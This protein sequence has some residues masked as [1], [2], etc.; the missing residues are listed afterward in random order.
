MTVDVAI[1]GGGPAGVTAAQELRRQ[2]VRDVMLLEREAYL[3]GATRHCAH[4]PFGMREFGRVLFGADY[5]RRLES[6]VARAGIDLRYG[7]SVT[8][9]SPEGSLNIANADGLYQITA[10][11]ILLATGARELPRAARMLPG[12]RPIGVITTGTL[13]SMIAF[14]HRLPFRRP[15]IIGSE[16]VTLS[17]LLT[18]R[19]HGIHPVAVVEPLAQSLT[20]APLSWFPRLMGVPFH[21]GVEILDIIGQGRVEVVRIRHN[22]H[23]KLI[24]CDGVLLTGRFTPEAS[25]LQMSGYTLNQAT[26]G[27]QV[28]QTGRLQDPHIFAAGNL[29]RPIETGGWA[30][31]EG[32]MI[33]RA[34][35]QDLT[36]DATETALIQ[37]S[38]DAPIRYV[39]P[40]LLRQTPNRQAG[41]QDFQLRVSRPVTGE[42]A[43]HIDGRAV[44]RLRNHWRPEKRIL[45]PIPTA[46]LTATA[47]HFAFTEHP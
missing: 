25:L 29:L 30:Y 44:F 28:D 4:S 31:R 20:N 12:D 10:R 43:L 13:Q 36:H 41:L 23:E 2:G 14:Q 6:E 47:I 46:A 32:R 9:I 33:A 5:G 3:G 34:I 45:L 8:Q 17:A 16:L 38:H 42:I 37:I 39:V 27:A 15:L 18:C 7:Q 22:G 1:I 26:G 35:A 21:T 19:T 11:R 24:D 40:N